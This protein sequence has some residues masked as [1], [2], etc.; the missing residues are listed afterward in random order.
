MKWKRSGRGSKEVIPLTHTAPCSAM[1]LFFIA[2]PKTLQIKVNRL[3]LFIV[4]KELKEQKIDRKPSRRC[5]HRNLTTTTR[6]NPQ[7]FP[8]MVSLLLI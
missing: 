1:F 7:T 5:Y 6:T 2:F 8:P 4:Q 3:S